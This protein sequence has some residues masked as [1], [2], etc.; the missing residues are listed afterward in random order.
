MEFFTNATILFLIV[1]T[2]GLDS[3]FGHLDDVMIVG[4]SFVVYSLSLCK[5]LYFEEHHHSYIITVTSTKKLFSKL[6]DQNVYHAHKFQD[7]ESKV[8]YLM[9]NQ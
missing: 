2:D 5:M 3:V 4:G 8:C 7:G 6:W 1:G 9:V